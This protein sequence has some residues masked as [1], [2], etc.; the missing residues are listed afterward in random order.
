MVEKDHKF[1]NSNKFIRSLT[2]ALCE[3]SLGKHNDLN[4]NELKSKLN[5][6]ASFIDRNKDFEME[7]IKAIFEFVSKNEYSSGKI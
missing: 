1:L 7:S 2:M 3:I 6:L 4:K 5:I